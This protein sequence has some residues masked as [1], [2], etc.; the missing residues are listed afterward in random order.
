MKNKN[1]IFTLLSLMILLLTG[2]GEGTPA[3]QATTL[4]AEN[5]LQVAKD[6]YTKQLGLSNNIAISKQLPGET[7]D[8][9]TLYLTKSVRSLGSHLNELVLRQGTSTLSITV[10]EANKYATVTLSGETSAKETIDMKT[11][12]LNNK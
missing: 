1:A 7:L 5:Y 6:V 11:F 10:D 12:T 2:C 9:N 3:H 8:V 4:N